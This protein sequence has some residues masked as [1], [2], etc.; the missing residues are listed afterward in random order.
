[1]KQC[2][3]DFGG[4]NNQDT[5][6]YE[7]Y[8]WDY[9]LTTAGPKGKLNVPADA[10][11]WDSSQGKWVSVGQNVMATTKVNF[12]LSRYIGTK[13]HDGSVISW[14][15]VLYTLYVN[16]ETVYNKKW[17]EISESNPN[18][19]SKIK[20]FRI[21][22]N[23]NIEIYLDAWH[24][25]EGMVADQALFTPN[26]WLLYA[27]TNDLIY[28]DNLMMA[29]LS[30]AKQYNVPAMNLLNK[31]HVAMV[32]NKID[33]LKVDNFNAIF[34]VGDKNYLTLDEMNIKKQNIHSWANEHSNLIIGEG[35]FY[36]DSYNINDETVNLKASRDSGY[37]F[38]L[39]GKSTN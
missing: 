3:R 30:K 34:T 33:G 26:N 38:P 15:D 17:N 13:W 12:D 18:S 4:W 5:L 6:E 19:I 14:A 9:K 1:M 39:K 28:K 16:Q 8:R 37:V 36:L 11:M 20:A 10:F 23:N 31:E 22:D 29:S 25:N 24:F 32:L 2:L 7:N 35:P 21:V 27:A